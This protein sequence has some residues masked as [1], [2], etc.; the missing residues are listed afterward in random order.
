MNHH[1]NRP[2]GILQPATVAQPPVA[3]VTGAAR[4]IGR[5]LALALARRNLA[6]AIHHNQSAA[7]AAALVHEIQDSGGTAIAI[8]ADFRDPETAA[9]L[10][11]HH[12]AKLGPVHVLINNASVF[13]DQPLQTIHTPHCNNQLAVNLLA[14][15]FLTQ[16]FANQLPA[17]SPGHVIN[18]LDWRALRPQ[19]RWL[20]YTAAKAALA[21]ATRTLALQLAP[22]IQV[23]AIAPGAIL[24]PDDLPEWHAERAKHSIPLQRTGSPEELVRAVNFL[25]DSRFITGEILHVSG[26]EELQ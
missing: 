16:Q 20:V 24:P 10:I 19:S 8:Q 7:A 17:N 13:D 12:A 21:A 2:P 1:E 5:Q 6:V 9:Q 23:N 3:L 4:R 11:F 22:V 15:L 14:P 26:G 18:I 25:L